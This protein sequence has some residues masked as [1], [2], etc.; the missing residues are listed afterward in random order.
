MHFPCPCALRTSPSKFSSIC[1]NIWLTAGLQP[2]NLASFR[3]Y[4]DSCYCLSLGS[5]AQLFHRSLFPTT[6]KQCS[7]PSAR[8]H[9]SP[10]YYSISVHCRISLVITY[11]RKPP[12]NARTDAHV[13]TL[14]RR[15]E[16]PV[17]CCLY[18]G[19][20]S[21]RTDVS[22]EPEASSFKVERICGRGTAYRS[23][24]AD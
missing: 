14:V 19:V 10:F 22:E 20:G 15:C 8:N 7:C 12:S 5:V 13:L 1:F 2:T 18:T 4:P 3:D 23:L 6:S 17:I 24:L 21:V 11:G 9:I 16:A